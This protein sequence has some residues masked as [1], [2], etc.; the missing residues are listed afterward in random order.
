MVFFTSIP[1]T[2]TGPP[3]CTPVDAGDRSWPG[4][5]FLH[6]RSYMNS[7]V[8]VTASHMTGTLPHWTG[9]DTWACPVSE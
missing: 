3:S 4:Q 2:P 1:G 7:A 9:V 6:Y 8:T 5:W